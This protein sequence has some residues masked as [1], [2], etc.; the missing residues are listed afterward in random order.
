M[1]VILDYGHGGI[2]DGVY[3]TA[4][5]KMYDFGDV[6]AYEG[7]INREIGEKI[8]HCLEQD[9]KVILTAPTEE[10]ISL[11]KRVEVANEIKDSIFISIHCNASPN[12]NASGFEIYTTHNRTKADVLALEIH[13]A[14]K[15]TLKQY[16]LKDRGIKEANFY[17]LRNTKMPSV[18]IECAFFD[19]RPDY[20]LLTNEQFQNDFASFVYTGIINYINIDL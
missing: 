3:T 17:V 1:N 6:I 8:K 15:P 7:V 19:Y 20:D 18:L 10:D 11:K 9:Y 2:I 5:K 4:P 14:V 16:G 12:H 13:N